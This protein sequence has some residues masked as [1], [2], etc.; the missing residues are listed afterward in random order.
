MVSVAL[1]VGPAYS[2]SEVGLS[3]GILRAASQVAEGLVDTLKEAS[4]HIANRMYRGTFAHPVTQRV[5]QVS[6]ADAYHGDEIKKW[7]SDHS[8]VSGPERNPTEPSAHEYLRRRY[9]DRYHMDGSPKTDEYARSLAALPDQ[10]HRIVAAHMKE[11]PNGGIW[12]GAGHLHDLGHAAWSTARRREHRPRGWPEGMTWDDAG[13]MYSLKFRALLVGHTPNSRDETVRHEFGHALDHA[14]REPSQGPIFSQFHAKVLRHLQ[15]TNPK[16]AEYYSQAGRAG[17][18][19]LFAEGFAWYSGTM[20]DPPHGVGGTAQ[21]EF[22]GS[23]AA[24]RH[25]TDF[26]RLLDKELRITR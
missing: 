17:K 16:S 19:E 13:G 3:S 8:A 25:L 21:P 18:Q 11:N 7:A 1:M 24:A 5:D 10:Y 14:L 23:A 4:D 15:V 26:Y 20:Q 6:L 22:Y 2:D 12:L 9:G